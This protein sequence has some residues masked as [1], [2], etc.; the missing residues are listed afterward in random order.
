MV[1]DKKNYRLILSLLI[2]KFEFAQHFLTLVAETLSI[3]LFSNNKNPTRVVT[4]K[5]TQN[6]MLV[7]KQ[8]YL[9]CE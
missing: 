1:C 2:P 6:S 9:I 5:E 3:G 7:R 8:T 4:F